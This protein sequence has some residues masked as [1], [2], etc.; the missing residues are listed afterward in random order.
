MTARLVQVTNVSTSVTK[1]Q[2]RALFTHLGRIE[3][4]QLYPESE[5][6]VATVGAKTG[7]IRFDRSELAQAALN[8]TN[9][10]FLDRPI[11]CSLVKPSSSSSSHYTRIPDETVAIK[12]CPPMNPNVGL[13]AGGITWPHNVINR[14]VNV[15]S[16][17]TVTSFIET[18]D[19]SLS[20]RSLPSYPR[21]PGSMDQQKAE[22]IRRTVYVSNLDPRVSFAHLY[23]LFNQVGEIRFIRLTNSL[24]HLQ[25]ENLGMSTLVIKQEHVDFEADSIGAYIE[26][27]E[28]P[29][30]PKALCL[31]GL[32]FAQRHIQVN[33]ATQS[34]T[35]PATTKQQ[36]SVDDLRK[37]ISKL[38]RQSSS[39]SSAAVSSSS[40]SSHRDRDGKGREREREHRDR[41]RRDHHRH[42]SHSSKHSKGET[43]V[44]SSRSVKLEKKA[45]SSVNSSPGQS[46][47]E[48]E[49]PM[50]AAVVATADSAESSGMTSPPPRKQRRSRSESKSKHESASK[51][52]KRSSRSPRERHHRSREREKQREKE[53]ER[54][55]DKVKS[56]ASS[57]SHHRSSASVSTKSAD[58]SKSSHRSS[59]NGTSSSKRSQSSRKRSTSRSGK[60]SKRSKSPKEDKHRSKDSKKSSHSS[61]RRSKSKEKSSSSRNHHG[62]SSHHKHSKSD[63]KKSSRESRDKK[64]SRHSSSAMVPPTTSSIKPRDYDEEEREAPMEVNDVEVAVKTEFDVY[65]PN[66][67]E[68]PH[69]NGNNVENM[70]EE[71]ETSSD[72]SSSSESSDQEEEEEEQAPVGLS[73]SSSGAET[74]LKSRGVLKDCGNEE[75]K[76][77]SSKSNGHGKS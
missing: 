38:K 44:A 25:C 13:I 34:V 69:R 24:K 74:P 28:Q 55:R 19:P 30:V 52:K 20:E 8:L 60:A 14:I 1:E 64:S 7:Y 47:E 3:D 35:I 51:S 50:E 27:S 43:T 54:E 75:A 62:S 67:V 18:V 29:S 71:H 36:I 66:P 17:H 46:D 56:S 68:V 26:F 45:D 70:N 77:A 4:I 2:L 6:L 73:E 33:H 76:R 22:E 48:D 40:S 23:E 11:I 37:E 12:L 61:K 59:T 10:V 9:T 15:S 49:E 72:N 53:R 42:E 65:G 58:A 32:M 21:L 63:T 41:E 16:G 39:S 57:S 31:N 5:T